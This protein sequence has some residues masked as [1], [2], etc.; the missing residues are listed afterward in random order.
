VRERWFEDYVPGT[1]VE[2]GPIRVEE[3]EVVEFARRFDPQPFHVDAAAA[4][5]GPFGG[6]IASGW[7]TC[8]LMMRLLAEEYL[9]PVSSLGSPGI[10]ELRW[11]LPVRPGDDLLLRTLVEDAR[12]SRS[13]P[14][15]GLVTTRV[16]M[17]DQAGSVVLRLRAVNLI[18]TRPDDS[19]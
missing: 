1:T 14:D 16:E 6:L 3:A 2:A 4:A 15:R 19:G 11:L 8:A 5:E 13:K 12:I 9:S 10:D 18:R 7:H 17:V